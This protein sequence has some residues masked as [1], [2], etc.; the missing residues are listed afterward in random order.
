MVLK[1]VLTFHPEEAKD[2]QCNLMCVTE[3]EKFV[4]PVRVIGPRRK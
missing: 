3:R 2:Y 1:Y 4:L